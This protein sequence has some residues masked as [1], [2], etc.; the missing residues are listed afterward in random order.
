MTETGPSTG[1]L[2]ALLALY[3]AAMAGI[4]F[5]ASRRVRSAEDFLLAGRRLGLGLSTATVFATWYGAGTLL[6]ASDEVAAEG[7]WRAG[8][9]PWGA[10]ICLLLVGV[11]FARPLW[12]LQ[13]TTLGDFYRRRFGPRAEIVASALMIPGYCGWVSVQLVALAEV[14]RLF[15][16]LDPMIG[17]LVVAVVGT[18]YTLVGGM[19][20]V[21]VTDALQLTFLMSGVVVLVALILLE[22]GGGS[23]GAGWERLL[24]E[25]PP[26]K[27]DFIGPNGL[28]FIGLLLAGALGNIPGQE[29]AQRVFSAKSEGTAQ[30]ACL[31]A[32]ASYLALGG[33]PLVGA[34]GANLLLVPDGEAIVVQAARHLFHP[35]VST[36]FFFAVVSAVLST[37]DSA[38]LAPASLLAENLWARWRPLDEQDGELSPAMLGRS[39]ASVLAIATASL[40]FAY[41]G[42]SAY[43]LLSSTYEL[44]MVCLLTPLGLGLFWGRGDER[45]ALASMAVDRKSVV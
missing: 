15:F 24:V 10:G 22:L 45:A 35:A 27:L 12:R 44:G 20:S 41:V 11:F 30:K 9:D 42:E 37:I 40:V 4:G 7:L 32:G 17:I 25:T 34:L 33:L 3:V 8:L 23:L 31:I 1:L 38:I 14:L 21:T 16:G 5:W 13:L 29:L 36:L 18:A 28:V 2:L 19:W 39:R 43:D 26:E 6:T